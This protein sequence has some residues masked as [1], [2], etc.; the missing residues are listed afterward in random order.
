[1]KVTNGPPLALG[2]MFGASAV[3]PPVVC[4]VGPAPAWAAPPTT[5]AN[6]I[7]VKAAKVKS[8]LGC[9][10][11]NSYGLFSGKFHPTSRINMH[12]S[13]KHHCLF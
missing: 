10:M 12:L 1:M 7:D 5:P 4:A 9:R 6:T 2:A 11:I 3:R 8:I 13:V